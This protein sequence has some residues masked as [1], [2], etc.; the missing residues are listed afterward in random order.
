MDCKSVKKLLLCVVSDWYC[1]NSGFRIPRIM[2]DKIA[3]ARCEKTLSTMK[4]LTDHIFVKCTWN[5]RSQLFAVAGQAV[6]FIDRLKQATAS[7]QFNS[8]Y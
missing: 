2:L 8:H 6:N 3:H 5:L 4:Y 7:F 1:Y